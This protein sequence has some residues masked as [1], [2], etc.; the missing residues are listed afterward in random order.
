MAGT[1]VAAFRDKGRMAYLMDLMP[2]KVIMNP[3]TALNGAGYCAA[4]L[5]MNEGG[6]R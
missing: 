1:F 4:L 3:L 6:A 5:A 2:V